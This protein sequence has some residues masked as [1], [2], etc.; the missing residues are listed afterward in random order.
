[1]R[2]LGISFSRR[3]PLVDRRS[4]RSEQDTIRTVVVHYKGGILKHIEAKYANTS[5]K[6]ITDGQS[7]GALNKDIGERII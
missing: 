6:D 7:I 5:Q 2:F 4:F 1:M 3:R